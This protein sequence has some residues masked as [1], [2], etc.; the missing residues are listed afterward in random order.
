MYKKLLYATLLLALPSISQGNFNAFDFSATN[1]AISTVTQSTLSRFN[2]YSFSPKIGEF[3]FNPQKTSLHEAPNSPTTLANYPKQQG[4]AYKTPAALAS[5]Y[6]P[7]KRNQAE[8]LFLDLLL[9]YQAIEKK[10]GI[11]R[12]DTA[13]AVAAFIS[14]SY[15]AYRDSDLP[16][17]HFQQLVEQIRHTLKGSR[18]YLLADNQHKQEVYEQM[19]ILGMFMATTRM[20]LQEKPNPQL[21]AN[22]RQAAKKYLEQFLKT[23]AGKIRITAKGL[24]IQ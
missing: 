16:D 17:S 2:D 13:G 7:N 6:P 21:S 12:H 23:D 1:S 20:A 5:K 24:I 8:K 14:G 3:E 15:M 4:G 9:G 19:A 18:H 10:F 22:L 11:P